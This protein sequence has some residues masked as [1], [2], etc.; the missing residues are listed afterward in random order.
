MGSDCTSHARDEVFSP[1][2]RLQSRLLRSISSSLPRAAAMANLPN[3]FYVIC[4]SS[5]KHDFVGRRTSDSEDTGDAPHRVISLP[6]P[7]DVEPPKVSIVQLNG[8]AC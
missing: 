7:P 1:T 4:S 5:D 8:R 3:G 6:L 2:R